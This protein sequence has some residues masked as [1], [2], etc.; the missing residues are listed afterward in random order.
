MGDFKAINNDYLLKR[1]KITGMEQA[2]QK[3]N[4]NRQDRVQSG[5]TFDDV[6]SKIKSHSEEVKFSKH[7]IDRL[8]ARNITLSD[9]EMNRINDAVDKA[10]K[11]GV[12]EALIMMDNKVFIAS[13]KNK[14][15][16]TAAVDNQ[17]KD[18][19]F[20]NIDGAVIV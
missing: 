13:V 17:L 14:T 11:K 15:I 16:I 3:T 12:N 6:L 2:N 18:N 4:K 1:S 8:S 5:K 7:A 10:S 20:T 19:V 9:S